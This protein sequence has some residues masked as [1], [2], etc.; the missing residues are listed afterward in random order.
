M[1]VVYLAGKFLDQRIPGYIRELCLLTD[2]KVTHNWTLEKDKSQRDAASFDIE[3]VSQCDIFVA[4]MDDMTYDYRGTFTELGAALALEKPILVV[5]GPFEQYART[6][7]FFL[8]PLVTHVDSFEVVLKLLKRPK[9][10]LI[11]GS[12]R[13]GKDTVAEYLSS[14]AGLRFASSSY[15]ANSVCVYPILKVKYGYKSEDECFLDRSNHRVEWKNLICDYNKEDKTRLTRE[16]LGRNEIYVGMRD[17]QELRESRNLFDL[18]IWVDASDRVKEK[19]P[20][21]GIKKEEADLIIEN[22]ESLFGLEKRLDNLICF[23]TK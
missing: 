18:I 8:H 19:D 13:H 1:R 9:K 22:N 5:K 17:D 4:I 15:T 10:F 12:G 20:S 7:C 6:N 16:I 21:L 14:K 2:I 11:I 3:G 23:I